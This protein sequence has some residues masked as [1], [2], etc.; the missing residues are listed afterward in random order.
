MKKLVIVFFATAL[1]LLMIA[2]VINTVTAISSPQTTFKYWRKNLY[3]LDFASQA[4][5]K[6]L[7]PLGIS[8]DPEKVVVGSEG[9]LYLGDG[10]AKSISTKRDGYSAAE[11][12]SLQS[13]A[14]N[15]ASWNTWFG[16]HGVKVF[17][18]VIGPDKDSIYPEHLPAWAAHTTPS[19]MDVLLSKSSS[20]LLI[21]P[22]NALREAKSLFP[23]A[24]YYKTDTHWN[25]IGGSIAFKAL[26]ASM[27][28]AEPAL[29]WPPQVTADDL[30]VSDK[31]GGDLAA[32]LR[33]R[34]VLHDNEVTFRHY[35]AAPLPVEQR[36]FFTGKAI[37]SMGSTDVLGLTTATLVT[38]PEALNNKRVLWLRDS[39]G[40]AMA[41]L[42]A[43]TF[44]ETLQ[45]H[46]NR[47]SQQMLTELLDKFKPEYVVVTHVERDVKGGFL[48]LRPVFEV[49]HSHDGFSTTR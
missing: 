19:S 9:W 18:V 48:S 30:I 14:D 7:Y 29:A 1:A 39:Y 42:M 32:F 20:N 22:K 21:Y 4:M 5:A 23:T 33:I 3:N 47:A 12:A 8:T 27:A 35:A 41:T 38:S 15:I 43:A 37:E 49:S 2:P 10:Y 34:S 13:I 17:R 11:D 28:T 44:R 24:L 40:T 45:L 46:H 6:Q 26:V 31:T 36:E 25:V 16:E